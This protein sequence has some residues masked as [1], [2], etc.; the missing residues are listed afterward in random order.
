MFR[1]TGDNTSPYAISDTLPQP[2]V[3]TNKGL[4]TQ[5]PLRLVNAVISGHAAVPDLCLGQVWLSQSEEPKDPLHGGCDEEGHFLGDVPDLARL[6]LV[7]CVAPG[8]SGEI[9]EV[10][11]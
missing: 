11:W 2:I 10:R 6:C 9:P 8:G 7:S 5:P 1:H 4:V 3:G